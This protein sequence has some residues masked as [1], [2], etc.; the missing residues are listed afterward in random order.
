LG[1]RHG[2]NVVQ[3]SIFENAWH[4][5]GMVAPPGQHLGHQIFL[6]H[7]FAARKI[8]DLDP[9]SARQF[10]R[11]VANALPQRVGKQSEVKG[12][13]TFPIQKCVHRFRMGDLGQRAGDHQSIKAPQ[14]ALVGGHWG[15]VQTFRH[16]VRM[17]PS[18]G[19]PLLH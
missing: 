4:Q 19:S 6:A 16:S 5:T 9:R 14:H 12:A 7:S 1:L 17:I 10:H 18:S 15:R 8:I 13:K 11:V 2:S 3:V